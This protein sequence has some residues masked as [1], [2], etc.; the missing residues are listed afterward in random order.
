MEKLGCRPAENCLLKSG[1]ILINE[2]KS[3]TSSLK[4]IPFTRDSERK[5]A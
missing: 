3:T 4:Y 1:E 5:K 2:N